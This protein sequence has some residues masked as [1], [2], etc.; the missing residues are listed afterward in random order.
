MVAPTLVWPAFE[1]ATH[2][3]RGQVRRR[4]DR[5]RPRPAP[6]A[7]AWAM[8]AAALGIVEAPPEAPVARLGEG[9]ACGDA[10][11]FRAE[12]VMLVPDRDR[13]VLARLD[14][15]PLSAAEADALIAATTEYFDAGE[16][17]LEQAP[18]GNWYAQAPGIAPEPEVAP[19]TAARQ[20]VGTELALGARA[21]LLNE[22]Q[23]LWHGHPVN[24][25]RSVTGRLQANALWL[26]GGGVLPAAPARPAGGTLVGSDVAVRGL[27]TWLR[28]PWAP[29]DLPAAEG[30]RPGAVIVVGAGE[31]DQATHWLEALSSDRRGFRMVTAAGDWRVPKRSLWRW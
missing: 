8:I 29:L 13:L 19:D 1:A 27:A 24:A 21:R 11:W 26:W 15:D 31:D 20:G 9:L 14:S 18:G 17:R 22:V 2:P 6:G 4:L 3:I 28:Q 10:P 7:D 25:A 5:A 16:L 30:A 12:P 23:M